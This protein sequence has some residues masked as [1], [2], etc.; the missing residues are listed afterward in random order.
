MAEIPESFTSPTAAAIFARHERDAEE[1]RRPHLGA[2]VVG[3]ECGRH[4]WYGF[5]WAAREQREGRMLRLLERGKREERWIIEEL[6]ALGWEVHDV[7]PA[8]GEQWL[9]SHLGGHFG[10][11]AD[12]AVLGVIE[13]PKTWHL[14]EIK[15]AN[16]KRYAELARKGVRVAFPGHWDQMQTYGHGLGLTRALYVCVCK[17]ND[18]VYTERVKI[19]RVEAEAIIN[20]A[21]L[22]IF[23]PQPLA[24]IKDDPSWYQCKLCHHRD[25]CQL[26]DPS[27]LERSCRTCASASP[28]EDGTWRCELFGKLLDVDA[29]RAGCD[30]HLFIPALLEPL[31]PVQ[32]DE[33][34]RA[35]IYKGA[36]RQVTDHGRRLE[37]LTSTASGIAG[38]HWKAA[39]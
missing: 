39:Q 3:H 7:D 24:R 6:R 25:H 38:E 13:A 30:Q 11:H 19:D 28:L 33:A 5:H 14:L 32:Y 27:S 18:D 23:S 35:M 1:W 22:A 12:G 10:G 17:D 20:R 29:Q 15:T 31:E 4:I 37:V 9:V 26:G 2:S 21:R 36:G 8:T 34:A 16:A